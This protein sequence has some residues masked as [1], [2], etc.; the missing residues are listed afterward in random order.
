MGSRGDAYT[1][2]GAPGRD[3]ARDFHAWQAEALHGAG[4]DFLYAALMPA[5]PESEGMAAAM[6]ST[7]L[8]CLFSFTLRRDGRLPDGT[9]LSDAICRVDEACARAGCKAPLCYMTNCVHPRL[10]REALLRP[11][12]R[13]DA[14]QRRFRGIQANASP[15]DMEVLDGA[16]GT[17]GA[18]AAVRMADILPHWPSWRK[19]RMRTLTESGCTNRKREQRFP[20]VPMGC[21]MREDSGS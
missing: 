6:G 12:N 5:L 3:E 21:S 8:P 9:A 11:F 13:T 7:G 15:L 20:T 17:Y 19:L 4:V 16:D 10:V 14:V 18:A 1:G 2:A